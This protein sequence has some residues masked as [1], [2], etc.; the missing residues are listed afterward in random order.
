MT[1]RINSN[2]RRGEKKLSDGHTLPVASI[3]VIMKVLRAN[4]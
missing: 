4:I 3:V 2:Y 1:V